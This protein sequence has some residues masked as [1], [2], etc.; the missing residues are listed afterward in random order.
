MAVKG[1][2]PPP[3]GCLSPENLLLQSSDLTAIPAAVTLMD[4]ALLAG[5]S[6]RTAVDGLFSSLPL[7]NQRLV[8]KHLAIYNLG[9][10]VLANLLLDMVLP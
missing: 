3:Q 2:T 8:L 7:T 9:R 10:P 5:L 4:M 1:V 6:T